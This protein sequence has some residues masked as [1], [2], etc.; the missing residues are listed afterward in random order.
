MP[1]KMP[2]KTPIKTPIETPIKMPIK[3]PFSQGPVQQK[4]GMHRADYATAQRGRHLAYVHT[5]L[6]HDAARCRVRVCAAAEGKGQDDIVRYDDTGGIS[7]FIW[8]HVTLLLETPTSA[9]TIT[10]TSTTRRRGKRKNRKNM[11]KR[12]HK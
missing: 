3:M 10:T 8:L 5:H 9:A 11:K 7:A 6:E 1:I 12:T 4:F 2:I